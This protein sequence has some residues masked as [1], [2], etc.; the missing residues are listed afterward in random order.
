MFCYL[1]DSLYDLSFSATHVRINLSRA[2]VCLM[3]PSLMVGMCIPWIVGWTI[4]KIMRPNA[5]YQN[6]VAP[7]ANTDGETDY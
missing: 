6:D 1:M 3:Q 5:T 2:I 4:T 7:F